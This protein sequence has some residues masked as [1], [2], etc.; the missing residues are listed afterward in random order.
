MPIPADVSVQ[1]LTICYVIEQMRKKPELP[2][3]LSQTSHSEYEAAIHRE[4]A[5]WQDLFQYKRADPQYAVALA[6]WRAAAD[7]LTALTQREL[8]KH[9]KLGR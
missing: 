7:A 1:M 5:A 6:E 3:Q 4:R 2:P 8:I 9:P